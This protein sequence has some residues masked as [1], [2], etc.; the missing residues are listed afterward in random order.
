M[1]PA[2]IDLVLGWGVVLIVAFNQTVVGGLLGLIAVLTMLRVQN[3]YRWMEIAKEAMAI[4]DSM[5]KATEGMVSHSK[6]LI[7]TT[8]RL[9]ALV[10][11]E[12]EN[13]RKSKV[14]H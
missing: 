2:R 7:E 12:E 3:L 14:V 11:P 10:F 9:A 4:T 5:L 13:E 8:D 6:E 1:T